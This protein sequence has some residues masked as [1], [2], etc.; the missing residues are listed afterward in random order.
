MKPFALLPVALGFS[1]GILNTLTLAAGRLVDSGEAI[2]PTLA[3]R[4][5][6]AAGIAG[7][8]ML[9][10]AEYAQ[11]RGDLARAEFMLN[12]GEHGRLI[13]SRQGARALRASAGA[14]LVSGG[15]AFIGSLLPLAVGMLAP[16]SARMLGLGVAIVALGALGA[17]LARAVHG[18]M[19]RWA[20]WMAGGGVVMGIVGVW[21][22]I[23]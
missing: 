2:T 9:F 16:Q 13:E 21:L 6:A 5:A 12:M 11:A 10:V 1:D 8:F 18:G 19:V 4:I 14:A 23:V 22:H 15:C 20:L 3:L 17:L 7:I